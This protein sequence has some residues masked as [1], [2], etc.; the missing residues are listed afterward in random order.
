[1]ND[2][3][4]QLTLADLMLGRR[5][6]DPLPTPA[7]TA[8]RP[9]AGLPPPP[10]PG[11]VLQQVAEAA[12]RAASEPPPP[13]PGYVMEPSQRLPDVN[14]SPEAEPSLMDQLKRSSVGALRSFAHGVASIPGMINDPIVHSLNWAEEKAGVD[15]RYR[16][17]TASQAADYLMN[18]AGVPE[19]TPQNA[20]ERVVNN[21]EEGLG[22]AVGT[23]GTGALMKGASNGVASSIGDMLTQNA[24]GQIASSAT[25]AGAAGVARENGAGTS[26]QIAAGLVGGVVPA[27]LSAGAQGAVR[28][29]I[30]GGEAGRQTVENNVKAFKVAG[31]TPTVGQATQSRVLQ[32]AESLLAKAPGSSGVVQ[33]SAERQADQ[34]S[35][36]IDALADQ[37]SKVRD[38]A[39]A[40]RTIDRGISGAGGFIDRFRQESGALYD[41][42]DNYIPA[43]KR[44]DVSNTME[45]LPE[46][47]PT[48]PGAPATSKLFQNARIRGIE[49]GLKADTGGPEAALTRPEVK[50]KADEL[51]QVLGDNNAAIESANAAG[52]QAV[53]DA[54]LLR[55]GTQ[56]QTFN[57]D[58]PLSQDEI[59]ANIRQLASTMVDGK[60]PYEA[61]KKLRTLVGNEMNNNSLV[62]DVPRS[63]WTA[64]YGALSRD[65]QNA[66]KEAGPKAQQAW[67]RANAYYRAGSSRIDSIA[68]VV[69]KSGGPEAIF[70]AATS[71]TRDGATT[72]RAVMQ[73][74]KPDEQKVLA[75]VMV[76]RLGRATPGAQNAAGDAFSMSSYLTNWNRLSP[77]AKKALFGRFGPKFSQDMDHLATMAENV[78]S[79]SKVFANPSGTAATAANIAA[80]TSMIGSLASGQLHTAGTIAAGVGSAN[81]VA[82]VM[83]NPRFVG[84]LA[85][86]T[87]LGIP[88]QAANL[89]NLRNMA[90]E[91]DDP[92]LK[93]M[94]DLVQNAQQEEAQGAVQ[95]EGQQEN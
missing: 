11:Y 53:D 23:M 4:N 8:P 45:L 36:G 18:K 29:A 93:A 21:I 52:K 25:G 80:W 24:G 30:R 75:S 78:R 41:K 63:K 57:P 2:D 61:L 6:G 37:L 90:Q 9:A 92:D 44:I 17:G 27:A 87:R 32:N 46:L 50:A 59:Q 54:N 70:N 47:N 14:V 65:L 13:P 83:T 38:P 72:L 68:S 51:A 89:A 60:L 31:T 33:Q 85:K 39:G 49:E 42:L 77:E 1:M 28:A 12:P 94:A 5:R 34:A 76:R 16:F 26:G 43:D 3:P 56:K 62:S 22:S 40:G 48:I 66:A 81:L 82:R 15:P 55:D 35:Q 84:W 20:T 88:P 73:S 91:H 67:N 19:Y 69:D 74:L 58:R 64:L 86:Q 71:G 10:P 7:P 79:G 95:T